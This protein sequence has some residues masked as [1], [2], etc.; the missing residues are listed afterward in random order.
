MRNFILSFILMSVVG[1]CFAG[2][3]THYVDS[4]VRQDGTSVEGHMAGNPGS[5]I[6]CHDNVCS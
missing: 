2:D 1:V 4:Y 3:G 5:G 6:H